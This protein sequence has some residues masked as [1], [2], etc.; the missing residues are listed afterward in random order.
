MSR[1]HRLPSSEVRKTLSVGRK[2]RVPVTAGPPDF[3][4]EV[5]LAIEPRELRRQVTVRL[6]RQYAGRRHRKSR[7]PECG[8][9]RDPFDDWH[10]L[11][12]ELES[13]QIEPLPQQHA[14]SRE[15]QETG[16]IVR[17]RC[18]R[19][20]AVSVERGGRDRERCTRSG[21]LPEFRPRYRNVRP[22]G[23]KYGQN[24]ST[25]TSFSV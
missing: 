5:A 11:F 17:R 19:S 16:G 12:A 4:Q 10:R 3:F 1:I 25:A 2:R 23:R 15:Q 9:S 8:V 18:S 14:S 20:P 6:E 13:R 21:P 22:S 24:A 7:Q